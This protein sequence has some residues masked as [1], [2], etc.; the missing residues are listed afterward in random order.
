[1]SPMNRDELIALIDRQPRATLTHLPTPL[2][3]YG[4]LLVKC[5]DQTGL[6]FGGSKLRM[7]EFFVGEALRRGAKVLVTAGSPQSNHC[8]LAAAAAAKCGLRCRLLIIGP[9]DGPSRASGNGWLS[10]IFGAETIPVDRVSAP[11]EIEDYLSRLQHEGVPFYFIEEGGHTPLA[12][13]GYLRASVELLSQLEAAGTVPERLF[14]ACGR[15]TTQAGLLLGLRLLGCRI[16]ILGA[17]VARDQ[18]RCMVEI[19]EVIA[20][21]CRQYDMKN[22]VAESDIEVDDRWVGGGYDAVSPERWQVVTDQARRNGLLL[23]P[24]YTSRAMQALLEHTRR[25]PG[26]TALLVHTGGLPGLFD[27]RPAENRTP[28]TENVRHSGSVAR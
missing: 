22:P 11:E 5:D 15:G 12:L 27:G 18:D 10:D 19:R 24:L 14:L 3:W 20:R 28:R 9:E 13:W 21:F 16:P 26:S 4:D 6:A 1:M 25:V 17:S 7:L 8:R 2:E 23:D